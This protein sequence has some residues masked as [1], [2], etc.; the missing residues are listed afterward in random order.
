MKNYVKPSD[1]YGD[2]FQIVRFLKQHGTDELFVTVRFNLPNC[3][4]DSEVT[5]PMA[6]V[7][8]RKFRDYIPDAFAMEGVRTSD[9]PEW[10]RS[11][12]NDALASATVETMLPQGFSFIDNHWVYALGNIVLNSS[13]GTCYTQDPLNLQ[14]NESDLNFQDLSSTLDWLKIFCEQGPAQSA[15]L[16]CALTPF[17]RPITERLCFPTR[18][19]NAYIWGQSG[20][21][22][23]EYAKLVSSLCKTS[24]AQ[25]TNLSCS[26]KAILDVHSQYQDYPFLIDDLNRTES[27]REFEKKRVV[28]QKSFSDHIVPDSFREMMKP[29]LIFR[30]PL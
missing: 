4:I 18:V 24:E 14:L 13:S 25:G 6:D 22:K 19:V 23:T 2:R 27:S 15:L 3:G 29:R 26:L 5:I 16:L 11:D 28:S 1:L 7:K 9:Q 8:S 30:V 12:I 21:G 17:I 20:T 10:L